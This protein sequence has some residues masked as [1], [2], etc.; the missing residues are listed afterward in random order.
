LANSA[1]A[2]IYGAG[3]LPAPGHALGFVGAG[4]CAGSLSATLAQRLIV[5]ELATPQQPPA[6][7]ERR[8]RSL[9]P[10]CGPER[11]QFSDSRDNLAPEVAELS[12]A[13]DRY[14]LMHRRRFI[15]VQELYQVVAGLGYHK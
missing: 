4:F 3:D 11:R 10:A 5:M 13:I 14:K 2:D 9:G 8:Q 12:Q 7:V 6:F 15:T 1:T